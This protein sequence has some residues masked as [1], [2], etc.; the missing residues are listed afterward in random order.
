[1]CRIAAKVLEAEPEQILPSSTGII[2]HLL[3]MDKIE[4]GIWDAGQYLGD[5]LEHAMLFADAILTTD[6]KRKSAATQVKI[7]RQTVT[8]AGVCKG[9]GMIGRGWR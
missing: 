4:A 3:P 6:L 8:V 5:S 7:G 2:G 9:S 1:M